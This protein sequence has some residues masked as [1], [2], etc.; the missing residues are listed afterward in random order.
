[1]SGTSLSRTRIPLGVLSQRAPTSRN[2]SISLRRLSHS[3]PHPNPKVGHTLDPSLQKLLQETDLSLLRSQRGKGAALKSENNRSDFDTSP[4]TG[5]E[6][7]LEEDE[8]QDAD[9]EN[10]PN[11]WHSR[12]EKRSPEAV[13]G[14]KHVGISLLP[15]ELE[16]AI[17]SLVNGAWFMQWRSEPHIA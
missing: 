16:N 4:S 11:A 3:V 5:A 8:F 2:P 14:S 1:M 15:L 7:Y 6:E 13:L 9:I 17:V 10:N 12:T